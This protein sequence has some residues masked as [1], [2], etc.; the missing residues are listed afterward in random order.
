M[1]KILKNKWLWAILI[2][3]I[4]GAGFYWYRV[5][6]NK[7]QQE[8]TT[9]DV[10]RGDLIQT[11]SATGAVQSA[12]EIELNFNSQGKITYLG[13]KEGDKVKAGQVLARLDAGSIA[14]QISQLRAAV[15]AANAE[16]ERVKAGAS[17]E[18]INLT[19]AQVTKAKSDIGSLI[20]DQANQLNTLEE[21]TTDNFN[22]AIF[23]AQTALDKIYNYFIKD[24]NTNQTMQF[25]DVQLLYYAENNYQIQV[26]DLSSIK[27]MAAAAKDS[28]NY[29]QIITASNNTRDYLQS[30]SDYLD[31]TFI[32]SQTIVTSATYPQTVKDGIKADLAAQ[33][34]AV[35]AALNSLQLA[36]TNLINASSSYQSQLDSLNNNLTISQAQL[37]L[38]KSGPRNFEL[39]SAQ[40]GV[41]QAQANLQGAI[42]LLEN[43]QITA[44]IDGEVTLVNY[45]VGE[46]TQTGQSVIKMIGKE[47]YEIKVDVSESDITKIKVGDKVSVELDA[48][49]S[50]HVFSGT[51]SFIDPAQTVIQ[52]VI[53]YK[54]TVSF[55]KDSWNEQIKPGMTANTTIATAEKNDALYIPQR[56]VK[57]REG[58]LNKPGDKYVEILGADNQIIEK[59]I[60]A[61]LKADNGLVEVLSGLNEGEKVIT[62]RK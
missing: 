31:K 33:Q 36:K 49:G 30:F 23:S 25:T 47:Q 29:D 11:V 48:F 22:N 7:N 59:T 6:A 50:D 18:D 26:K 60:T 12:K 43:Y 46:Q 53:Y 37:N 51:V 27:A 19:S 34:T 42:S 44:P 45:E 61:G 5:S 9:E 54:A 38:K 32:L 21:K 56:A 14:A 58:T 41:S 10:K 35:S 62:F 28:G 20:S 2:I 13:V 16:L 15:S 55:D 4:A 1:K 8:I 3:I 24:Y 40:A 57:I 52:D 17:A 39:A